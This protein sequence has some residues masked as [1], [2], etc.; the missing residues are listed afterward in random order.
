MFSNE[1]HG[2]R[3]SHS[4]LNTPPPRQAASCTEQGVPL[5]LPVLSNVAELGQDAS[6]RRAE[7]LRQLRLLATKSLKNEAHGTTLLHFKLQIYA[8]LLR[9]NPAVPGNASTSTRMPGGSV[10]RQVHQ[11]LLTKLASDIIK[12]KFRVLLPRS[13]AYKWSSH[14]KPTLCTQTN[15]YMGGL[16]PCAVHLLLIMTGKPL[17]KPSRS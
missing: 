4:I 10:P 13:T 8:P 9:S 16:G 2:I 3:T 5:R 7:S 11:A 15:K 6:P 14:F 1:V 17:L 12:G